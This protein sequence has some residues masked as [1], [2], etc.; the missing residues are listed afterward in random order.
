MSLK[1]I[2]L[3]LSKQYKPNK[4]NIKTYSLL[5][6]RRWRVEHM[7]AWSQ[8][9]WRGLLGLVY[10]WVIFGEAQWVHMSSGEGYV[11]R[12]KSDECELYVT[13][14]DEQSLLG[15]YCWLY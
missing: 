6:R 8:L 11:E 13:T 5:G 9:A 15:Y 1:F 10:I 12:V 4:C 2:K 14:L 3:P 7:E